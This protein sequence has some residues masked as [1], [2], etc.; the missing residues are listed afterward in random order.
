M[1]EAQTL[2]DHFNMRPLPVEGTYY[3]NTYIAETTTA[4]GTPAG[5]AILGLYADDPPSISRFHRLDADEIWH[6]YG[7]DPFRLI[8][9]HPDG[10]SDDIIMGHD[11]AAG[12]HVQYVVRAGIWQAGHLIAGGRYAFYGTTMS[13]GF[14]A[15]GFEAG[16]VSDLLARYPNR[17]ADIER[18]AVPDDTNHTMPPG[19]V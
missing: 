16:T 4:D 8:L 14:T 18:Y 5:T 6:V 9:L 2:I 1:T 3:V 13:P 10:T 12:H 19:T 11:L 15:A 17:H 7:G